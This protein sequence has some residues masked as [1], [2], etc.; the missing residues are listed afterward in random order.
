VDSIPV[1][2]PRKTM[3]QFSFNT[4]LGACIKLAEFSIMENIIYSGKTIVYGWFIPPCLCVTIIALL[5]QQ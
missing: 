1:Q 5:Y 2:V 4:D 3:L